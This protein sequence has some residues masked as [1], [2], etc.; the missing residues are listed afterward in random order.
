[1]PFEGDDDRTRR[2]SRVPAQSADK[3]LDASVAP[4][5]TVA[6]HQVLVDRPGVASLAERQLD[7]VEVGLAC[8]P[9]GTSPG[10]RERRRVGGH[11]WPVLTGRSGSGVGG[12]LVGRFF[13]RA[14]PPTAGSPNGDSGGLQVSSRRF[15]PNARFLLDA[16]QRPTQPTQRDDLLSFLFVQDIAHVNGG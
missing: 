14:P 3:S 6:V 12:H 9:G 2:L 1:M 4:R 5:E 8:A 7:E 11:R 10:Q 13:R 15:S 16:P